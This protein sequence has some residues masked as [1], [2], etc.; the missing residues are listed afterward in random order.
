[1]C[2]MSTGTPA[3]PCW[4]AAAGMAWSSCGMRGRSPR[5]QAWQRCTA[6][7][8]RSTRW[9]VGVKIKCYA[10]QLTGLHM[11]RGCL[12]AGKS[13]PGWSVSCCFLTAVSRRLAAAPA[14]GCAQVKWNANGTWLL[15]ASRDQ[16]VRVWDIRHTKK[17]LNSWQGHTREVY[18]VAWH[19]VHLELLVSG[20]WQCICFVSM[21]AN[22]YSASIG[23]TAALC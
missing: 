17:E 1:M 12:C 21:P 3:A 22:A 6:T 15:S 4:P 9:A 23:N 5:Q 18:A 7:R 11:S 20:G 19:P 2:A 13:D 8:G 10:W 14:A 16:T